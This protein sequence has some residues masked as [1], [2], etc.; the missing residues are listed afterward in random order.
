MFQQLHVVLRPAEVQ[1]RRSGL[2]R[3]R[4]GDVRAFAVAHGR[5]NGGE[6]WRAA[7]QRLAE[8]LA[9]QAGGSGSLHVVVS[10]HFA[11]YA[12]VPWSLDVV[13]DS[14]RAAL[15]RISLSEVFGAA[16]DGWMVA[17]DEPPAGSPCLACGIDRAM[18]QALKD[19]GG[20]LRM[21]LAS[22]TPALVARINR[23]RRALSAPTLCVASVE[24]DRLTLAF[25]QGGA[26]LAVR[27]RRVDGQAVEGLAAA[28]RQEA[29]AGGVTGG[30]TLYLVG[31]GV[32]ALPAFALPEWNIERLEE[33]VVSRIRENAL[34]PVQSN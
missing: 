1:V 24:P 18:F 12:V 2:L 6:P 4:G 11:R 19:L 22:V 14:E 20:A 21:R 10:D 31:E 32:G 30:G 5:G 34:V 16:A 15:G 29:A 23:H 28:L 8:V 27:S 3:G 33:G 25:R 13:T 17:L 9:E 7:V 26:W